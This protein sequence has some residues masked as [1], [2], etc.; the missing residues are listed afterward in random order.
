MIDRAKEILVNLEKGEY[1]EGGVP[2]LA[3]G[4]QKPAPS[5]QPT[6]ARQASP[7]AADPSPAFPGL[8]PTEPAS[9][10]LELQRALAERILA[11]DGAQVAEPATLEPRHRQALARHEAGLATYRELARLSLCEPLE[12]VFPVAR[13]LLESTG[14]WDGL[15][16]GFL[17]AR[18]LGSPH[19]RDVAP[20]F[21]GWVARTGQGLDRCPAL[22]ELLHFELLDSIVERWPDEPFPGPE[23]RPGPPD[24][25]DRLVLA[26]GT[27]V[28]A[29]AFAVHQATLERPQPLLGPT[30]L[31]AYRD[32][33]GDFHLLELTP[34]TAA[35]LMAAQQQPIRIAAA[36]LGLTQ[37]EPILT[38]LESFRQ[39]GALAG[40]RT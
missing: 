11:P 22:L 5:P 31:M 33:C 30:H 8:R 28:I 21:L 37:L 35:L 36:S 29:Y 24:P 12:N 20:A 39:T 3:R 38:L 40:F 26:A 19:Y 18:C 2:R 27:L 34:A 14:T 16:D 4:K 1:G 32:A 13:T 25:D 6:R 23:P 9:A 10:T 15:V 17:A 7:F